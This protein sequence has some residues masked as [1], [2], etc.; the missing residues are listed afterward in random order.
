[1]WNRFTNLVGIGR[2]TTVDD[3]GEVQHMQVTEGAAGAGFIDR[4]IDKVRRITEFGFASV[5]PVDS[6]V[7]M[8]RRGGDRSCSI[9]I[10]TSHRPSRPKDL[11]PGDVAIYDVRGAIVKL[12]AAGVE[13]DGAGLEVKFTNCPSVTLNA[14]DVVMTGTLHVDGEITGLAGGATVSLGALRD[15][16]NAHHHTGVTTGGGSSGATDQPL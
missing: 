14:P 15:A 6:E 2:M 10:G 5:P 12:T 1:M 7:V 11:Q 9:V 8:I 16:Y 3:S 13:I 4:V